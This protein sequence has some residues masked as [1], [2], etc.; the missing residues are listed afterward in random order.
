MNLGGNNYGISGIRHAESFT[1]M[2]GSSGRIS[3]SSTIFSIVSNT[4]LDLLIH[5]TYSVH[6]PFTKYVTYMP[7]QFTKGHCEAL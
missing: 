3:S 7:Q 5:T 6:F 4:K 1:N 2:T